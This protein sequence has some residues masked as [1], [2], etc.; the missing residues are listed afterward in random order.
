MYHAVPHTERIITA[1]P[2]LHVHLNDIDDLDDMEGWPARISAAAPG[3]RPDERR[4]GERRFGGAEAI[5][6]KRADRRK[7]VYRPAKRA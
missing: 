3:A 5:D 1:M 6:R 4:R 2:R 7:Q